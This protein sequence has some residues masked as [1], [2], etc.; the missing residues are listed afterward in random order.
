MMLLENMDLVL[1]TLKQKVRNDNN[2]NS[3]ATRICEIWT[4]WQSILATICSACKL[5][6]EEIDQLK[7]D[8]KYFSDV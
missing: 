4:L 2:L 7:I 8:I 6:L 1:L 3:T 5:S